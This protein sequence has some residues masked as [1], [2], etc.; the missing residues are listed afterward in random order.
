MTYWWRPESG[1]FDTE[2]LA[3]LG[4]LPRFADQASAEQW[5]TAHYEDLSEQG[6]VEVSLV[7]VDRLV[8][9]PMSLEA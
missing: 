9:G 1:S 3:G 4:L 5:L 8:Y 6:V 7:D 2:A